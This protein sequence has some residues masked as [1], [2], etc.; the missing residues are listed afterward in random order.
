MANGSDLVVKAT[1]EAV[2]AVMRLI[3]ELKASLG[4]AADRRAVDVNA[5]MV[6]AAMLRWAAGTAAAAE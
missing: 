5:V 3:A 2:A 1:D 6:H 4:D